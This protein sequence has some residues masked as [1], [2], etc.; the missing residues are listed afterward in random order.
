MNKLGEILTN[1]RE[2]IKYKAETPTKIITLINDN[3]ACFEREIDLGTLQRACPEIGHYFKYIEGKKR[4]NNAK[5]D[6][7]VPND[8]RDFYIK[9]EFSGI[10]EIQEAALVQSKIIYNISKPKT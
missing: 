3:G 6:R 1:L 7:R 10:K 2:E 8:Y 9:D 5:W 4:P